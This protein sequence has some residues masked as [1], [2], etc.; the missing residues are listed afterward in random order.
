MSKTPINELEFLI[1]HMVREAFDPN[2]NGIW[3]T[4]NPI[5]Q[6]NI[7]RQAIEPVG[8]DEKTFVADETFLLTLKKIHTFSKTYSQLLGELLQARM[9]GFEDEVKAMHVKILQKLQHIAVAASVTDSNIKVEAPKV[10]D[11]SSVPLED[12]TIHMF[13]NLNSKLLE[14]MQLETKLMQM[15]LKRVRHEPK[16]TSK[17]AGEDIL[18]LYNT[19]LR[20]LEEIVSLIAEVNPLITISVLKIK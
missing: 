18:K 9:Q 15:S 13:R 6:R 8:F 1:R 11:Y 14:Y 4:K 3:Q 17:T 20:K 16:T 5:A 7:D 19:V 10:V 12:K 2:K